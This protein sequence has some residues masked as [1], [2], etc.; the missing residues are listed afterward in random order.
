MS[1]ADDRPGTVA[2]ENAPVVPGAQGAGAAE[3]NDVG[4]DDAQVLHLGF[5]VDVPKQALAAPGLN[6]QI[7]Y[8]V[9][10]SVEGAPQKRDYRGGPDRAGQVNVRGQDIMLPW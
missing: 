10:P 8:R 9:T 7:A 1:S 2:V 6:A 5:T 4:V 3:A